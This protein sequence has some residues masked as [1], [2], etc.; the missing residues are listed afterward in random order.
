MKKYSITASFVLLFSSSILV[1]TACGANAPAPTPTKAMEM[2]QTEAVGTFA[3]GLTQTMLAMPTNTPTYTPTSTAT[4]T[5]TRSTPLA[6][7]TGLVPTTSCYNLKGISD[8]TIPDNTPMTAGQTF[9][10]TW[11]VRNTG[12]CT[13]EV[14][15]KLAFTGNEAMGGTTQLLSKEVKPGE[16]I[17]LSVPMTAPS[18]KTGALRGNWHLSTANG[19]FFGDELWVIIV[20]GGPTS[21]AST[22]VPPTETFTPTASAT[23]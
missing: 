23:P 16:E 14:G 21:T 2:I 18:D 15:F 20:L 13:W 12:T 1:L 17:E 8:V 11:R 9:T 7:S 3:A 5:A 10:K 4:A 19:V 22:T 6:P